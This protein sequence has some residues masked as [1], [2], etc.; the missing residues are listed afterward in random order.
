M[1]E[2]NDRS[3]VSQQRSHYIICM[4]YCLH[5]CFII[6]WLFLINSAL[7]DSTVKA[8]GVPGELWGLFVLHL[9]SRPSNGSSSLIKDKTNF[10]WTNGGVG[11]SRGDGCPP[12]PLPMFVSSLPV[13][14]NDPSK[15]EHGWKRLFSVERP[16][17][18]GNPLPLL[19]Q[20][21]FLGPRQPF[22]HQYHIYT[23]W[24]GCVDGLP[25]LHESFLAEM[26]APWEPVD[27]DFFIPA[28][29]LMDRLAGWSVGDEFVCVRRGWKHFYLKMSCLRGPSNWVMDT[30][31]QTWRRGVSFVSR[32]A[33]CWGLWRPRGSISELVVTP[34]PKQAAFV[35]TSVKVNYGSPE[36]S[37]ESVFLWSLLLR[38]WCFLVCLK[39]D[40]YHMLQ[41]QRTHAAA[42]FLPSG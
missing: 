34:Q 8:G 16:A 29:T 1:I 40:R 33:A 22:K 20:G 15:R 42:A 2:A 32:S 4:C 25:R 11:L 36:Q 38:V 39:C 12:S 35:L 3:V 13:Y 19:W 37:Q 10:I 6:K 7:I 9:A 23:L 5:N 17:C 30:C 31:V 26:D 41:R 14:K 21:A 24:V 28:H 27:I 18:L